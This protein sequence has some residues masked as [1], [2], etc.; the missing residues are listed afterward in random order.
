MKKLLV[1]TSAL[2]AAAGSAA[3]LDVT[4]GGEISISSVLNINDSGFTAA[5]WDAGFTLAAEGESMGWV[6]G[7]T[8]EFG[9]GTV[10]TVAALSNNVLALGLNSMGVFVDAATVYMEGDFMGRVA[11]QDECGDFADI[12]D[13]LEKIVGNVGV[14]AGDHCLEWSGFEI[15]GVELMAA[16]SL[17]AVGGDT[18]IIGATTEM[19]GFNVAAEYSVETENYDVIVDGEM[20]GLGVYLDFTYNNTAVDQYDYAVGASME[21]MDD[22]TV[23][24]S[25]AP[26]AR[27]SNGKDIMAKIEKG[28]LTASVGVDPVDDD[29]DADGLYMWEVGYECDLHDGFE[30]EAVIGVD[31]DS[32]TGE[33]VYG[34]IGATVSF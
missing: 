29:I 12:A 17:D 31:Q 34:L 14:V 27:A 11:V 26:E 22:T 4:L 18:A 2:V 23:M 21:L 28:C 15:A 8:L 20:A 16:L 24:V 3:A 9:M 19:Y 13:S 10:I 33:D 6:Y 32:A 5:N 1:A 30:I 25:Y 7:G